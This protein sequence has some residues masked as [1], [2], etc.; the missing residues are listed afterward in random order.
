MSL[1]SL[2]AAAQDSSAVRGT[3]KI[4]K[5]MSR[6]YIRAAAKYTGFG[7]NDD[8]VVI[9]QQ[10]EPM[11][12]FNDDV[13]EERNFDYTSFFSQN[14]RNTPIELKG[15]LGDT[16]R[17]H[18]RVTK[19][20]KVYFNEKPQGERDMFTYA[21]SSNGLLESQCLQQLLA[22]PRWKPAFM[23]V[24]RRTTLKKQTVIKPVEQEVE[25]K[26]IITVIFSRE[27]FV[28]DSDD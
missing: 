22:I 28:A 5:E 15:R 10:Q 2:R 24:A 12:Q 7:L 6:V 18:I 16:V 1:L 21:V 19:N 25:V 17:I 8:R 4:R 27:P 3:I 9:V 20:G 11:P 23:S 26:G 14:F 13:L